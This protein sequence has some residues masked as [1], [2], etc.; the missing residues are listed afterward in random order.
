MAQALSVKLAGL[1]TYPSDIGSAPPGALSV[2]DNIVIDRDQVAEPRRGF[3]YLRH[4]GVKSSFPNSTYRARRMFFYGGYGMALYN[5]P[6]VTTNSTIGYHDPTT[7]WNAI[8]T[9]TEPTGQPM[10]SVQANSNFY[11][12]T[13]LGVYKLDQVTAGERAGGEGGVAANRRRGWGTQ[14]KM[15]GAQSQAA[16]PEH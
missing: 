2:A 11:F 3:D 14:S 9:I 6:G 5:T 4:A 7:G 12:T 10:R 15:P 8:G 13:N 16:R 1:Y